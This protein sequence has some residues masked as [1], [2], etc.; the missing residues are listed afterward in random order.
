MMK[1]VIIGFA[2][3]RQLATGSKQN[4]T[5]PNVSLETHGT[6]C[7]GLDRGRPKEHGGPSQHSRPEGLVSAVA[8]EG[9]LLADNLSVVAISAYRQGRQSR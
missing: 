8:S 2:N 3:T 7:L 5:K 1:P 4:A 6:V 9:L